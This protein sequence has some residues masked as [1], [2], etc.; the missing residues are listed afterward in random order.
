MRSIVFVAAIVV[1]VLVPAVALYR[2]LRV[3]RAFSTAAEQATY[4]VLHRANEAA[5]PFRAGLTTAAAAKSIRVLHQLLGS[6]AVA[7]TNETDLLAWDGVADHHGLQASLLAAEVVASGRSKVVPAAELSCTDPYCAIRSAVIVPIVVGDDVVGTLAAFG[8][9]TR[10]G[11]IRATTEVARWVSTQVELA[12]LD[13]SR[14]RLAEAEVRALRAQISPHFIFNAMTAIASF[15]RSDPERARDLLLEFA[16]FTRYSFRSHGQFTTLAEELRSIDK[17]LVLE[18]AR[19]GDRLQVTLQIAPEVL[20][21]AV[22][23]FVLQPLVENAVRHGLEKKPGQGHITIVAADSGPEARITV[24][25]DG[26][27]MDPQL[28]RSSLAGRNGASIGLANVD[29]R[30]RTVFGAD[31]GLVVETAPG[32]GTKVSLRIPKYRSGVRAS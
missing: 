22:P 7:L 8:S 4:N 20:P 25:D 2:V 24:E 28:V 16:D 27:G 32:A 11:M 5:P 21:V 10:P 17:Y 23:V 13:V 1:T 15:V 9:D 30:L 6:S 3:R 19:F 26:V 14:A 31:F 29:E 18:R 12:E